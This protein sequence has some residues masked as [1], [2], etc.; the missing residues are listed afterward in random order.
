MAQREPVPLTTRRSEWVKDYKKERNKRDARDGLPTKALFKVYKGHLSSITCLDH[1][2]IDHREFLFSGSLDATA[3]M[4]NVATGDCLHVFEGHRAPITALKYQGIKGHQVMAEQSRVIE[5]SLAPKWGD[6]EQDRWVFTLDN[7]YKNLRF[8]MFDFD[9]VGAHDYMGQIDLDLRKHFLK[10]KEERNPRIKRWFPLTRMGKPAGTLHAELSWQNEKQQLSVFLLE[11]KD[12]LRMDGVLMKSDPYVVVSVTDQVLPRLFTASEDK[13]IKLWSIDSGMVLQNFTGHTR[14]VTSISVNTC[15]GKTVLLS[16]SIDKTV[17]IWSLKD[18]SCTNSFVHPASVNCCVL[19]VIPEKGLKRT[20]EEEQIGLPSEVLVRTELEFDVIANTKLLSVNVV[21]AIHLPVMDTDFGGGMCDPYVVITVG[22][23]SQKGR[24]E[25]KTLNP[26]WNQTFEFDSFNFTDDLIVRFFDWDLIGEHDY[27]GHVSIM[28]EPLKTKRKMKEWYL[29]D[30]EP[31]GDVRLF[32]ACADHRLRMMDVRTGKVLNTFVGHKGPVNEVH[33]CELHD[34]AHMFS[35]SLDATVKLWE[36]KNKDLHHANAASETRPLKSWRFPTAV[37]GFQP[38]IIME[39][40]R[41]F[42]GCQ[43]AVA[44]M[45]TMDLSIVVADSGWK[46]ALAK[47][48][49]SISFSVFILVLIILDIA[50]GLYYDDSIN[51]S[52]DIVDCFA[53]ESMVASII[54]SFVLWVFCQEIFSQFLIRGRHFLVPFSS[55]KL[56]NYADL[57]IVAISVGVSAYKVGIDYSQDVW[58]SANNYIPPTLQ[59]DSILGK[60]YCPDEAGG[61]QGKETQKAAT[62]FRAARVMGRIATAIRILRALVKAARIA[63]KLGG[64]RGRKY[65]GHDKAVVALK[66]M[67][68]VEKPKKRKSLLK[69]LTQLRFKSQE[70]KA[71]EAWRASYENKWRLLTGSADCSLIMWD[72]LGTTLRTDRSDF[73]DDEVSKLPIAELAV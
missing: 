64:R 72:I 62:G 3:R 49:D 61:G 37:Y 12:L 2:V 20:V 26:V 7:V 25:R 59:Q 46:Q 38:M 18:G 13:V 43:D 23:E 52:K 54:T 45:R 55:N 21:K 69:G 63:Q 35:S 50:I 71:L 29:I 5:Q 8:K 24:V 36:L 19:E 30:Y 67:P 10:G 73:V 41:L 60:M 70:N 57:S 11:A 16:A 66:V 42:A 31:F 1:G 44:Y 58:D 9:D 27:I 28:L 6:R 56:W 32:T 14:P 65:T 22:E 48:L 53:R 39:N 4:F 68:P 51:P 17:K 47:M 34:K 40:L 33:L 15:F